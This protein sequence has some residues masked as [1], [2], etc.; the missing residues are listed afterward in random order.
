MSD[1]PASPDGED[2]P[3]HKRLEDMDEEERRQFEEAAEEINREAAEATQLSESER[4]AL[5]ALAEPIETE[6]ERVELRRGIEVDVRTYL[7][8]EMEDNLHKIA[9]HEDEEDLSEIR[10]TL[11]ETTAWLIE[12]PEYGQKRVWAIHA[13]EYG[14]AALAELFYK[15]VEPA[16][17][18]VEKSEVTQKFR[19]GR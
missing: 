17:Q 4:E 8:A 9:D 15:A 11:A 1:A 16:L 19:T 13:E 12:H 6:T 3:L 5:D 2:E 7:S 18:R 10:D 14:S